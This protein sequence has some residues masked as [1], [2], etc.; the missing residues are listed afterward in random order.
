MT[1]LA[2]QQQQVATK[3]LPLLA[4]QQSSEAGFEQATQP[5]AFNVLH[6]SWVWLQWPGKPCVAC[7]YASWPDCQLPSVGPTPLVK[8]HAGQR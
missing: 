7:L 3:V 4:T 5:A 8:P 2:L 6:V 1:V